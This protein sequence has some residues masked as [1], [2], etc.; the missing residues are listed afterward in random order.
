[1]SL[2]GS[3]YTTKEV[4]VP[5]HAIHKRVATGGKNDVGGPSVK[6]PVYD[7]EAQ[8]GDAVYQDEDGLHDVA[9]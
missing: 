7:H 8:A 1:M 3:P 4:A 9:S 6:N 2:I 5:R